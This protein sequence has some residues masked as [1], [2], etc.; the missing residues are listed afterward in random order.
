[1]HRVRFRLF[2]SVHGAGLAALLV[3]CQASAPRPHPEQDIAQALG[4]EAAIE[5]SVE[6]LDADDGVPARLEL[7]DALGRALRTSPE[8]LSALAR[9]Q[10]ALAEAD[11]ARLL[12]NP[13]LDLVL[14]FPEG[15][16]SVALETGLGQE[17]L[18]YLRRP[19]RIAAAD[20]RLQ[21][22]VAE[23]VATSLSVVAE[24]REG[25]ASVQALD[26]LTLL[27]V[28]RGRILA[29]LTELARLR[30]A[31]GEASR[32]DVLALETK[33]IELEI[34]LAEREAERVEERLS[35]ARAIG[36]PTLPASWP[37]E[38]WAAVPAEL[39]DEEVWIRVALE[40]RPELAVLR[41]ELAALGD[42]RAL[43]G[44]AAFEGASAGLAA[45]RDGGWSLGPSVALP[46][47]LFDDGSARE[48]HARA[49]VLAARG[50]LLGGERHVVAE[51]RRAHAAFSA[52]RANL[53]RVRT[54]LVPLL[55]DRRAQVEAVY[56][57]GEADVTTV[58]LAEQDLQEAQSKLVE[59][60]KE[61]ALSLV[62]LERAVGG[63]GV[64][65]E[66]ATAGSE[67]ASVLEEGERDRE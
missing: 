57:A 51:V 29:Q 20:K 34:E 44:S 32:L 56:L 31:A 61:T 27:L 21:A 43:A 60:E 67:S 25:Y 53:E 37:L 55:R 58:L 49:A 36:T 30:L 50:E 45:E 59:L 3:A 4:L 22:A 65:R 2:P 9:V 54:R 10:Q 35:L 6:G 41:L 40:R 52:A 33:G 66:L 62:R 24:L 23:A 19:R 47:P 38:P 8:L 46:L 17:L 39:A 48:A 11:Q 26:E 12:S 16:G 64:A 42:E 1:M 7:A 15:G 13:I 28:E 18:Q 63:A 14:R 5:L